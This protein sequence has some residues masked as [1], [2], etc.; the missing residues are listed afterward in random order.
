MSRAERDLIKLVTD[1]AGAAAPGAAATLLRNR[2]WSSS[3]FSGI[4]LTVEVAA[5]EDEAFETW[6]ADLSEADFQ[7]RGY[8]VA[9]A[10]LIERRDGAAVV[11]FLLVEEN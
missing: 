10:D 5:P 2:D 1:S 7:P 9:S 11:E 8:F 4:R 6:L 3:L